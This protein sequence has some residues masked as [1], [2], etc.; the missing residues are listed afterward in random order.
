MNE[1]EAPLQ[2]GM[3]EQTMA[4]FRAKKITLAPGS[5]GQTEIRAEATT[6]LI[7]LLSVTGVVLL[8]ACANIANLLLV[9]GAGRAGEMAVR[10]SIGATA[11]QLIAQLL[12]ESLVLAAMG[13]VLGLMVSR[14]TLDA[15][16]AQL[17]P[18]NFN[19]RF[20]NRSRGHSSPV[21]WRSAQDFSSVCSRR[22]IAR[23]P[24]W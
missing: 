11:R 5:R 24:V 10:L 4:R 18:D 20:P 9:R 1:V 12:V 16:A 8:I 15:I 19:H 2:Q 7:L 17:P 3:S 21:P 23:A 6:P 22:F 14:W 13:A